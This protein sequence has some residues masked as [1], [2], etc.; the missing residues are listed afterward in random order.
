MEWVISMN[1]LW[2]AVRD[3]LGF[4]LVC[5]VVV[6]GVVAIAKVSERFFLPVRQISQARRITIVAMCGAIAMVL[7]VF[8]FSVPFLAPPFYKLDFS[9]VPVLL[10]GFFLGPSAG[11]VC[12]ALKILLKLLIKSTSTAFVGDLANFVVGCFFVVPA[13]VVYH[14]RKSKRSAVVGLVAGTLTMAVFGS[15]F[16][17]VYL[18][19]AF[20]RLYQMP[21][22]AII[23]L[24][25]QIFPSVH[26]VTSLVIACVAPLNLL[27]GVMVSVLTLV[28]YKRVEK[29]L[30]KLSGQC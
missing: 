18:I 12:E 23:A 1:E 4:L 30:F 15:F 26:S 20:S 9:E 19:P 7:H 27:K 21:L 8:D 25:T 3:N 24:G 13:T 16:N 5:M 11:V 22:D 17:A 2:L 14:L 28:L 10:C 29:P 6:A